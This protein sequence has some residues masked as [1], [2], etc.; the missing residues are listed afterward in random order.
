MMLLFCNKEKYE[1]TTSDWIED[2]Y[3]TS[4]NHLK[5]LL[6]ENEI[7]KAKII[8]ESSV[9]SN[10]YTMEEKLADCKILNRLIEELN[11]QRKDSIEISPHHSKERYGRDCFQVSSKK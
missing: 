1:K 7:S 11:P 8:I 2:K 3:Q 10:K 5:E 9:E 6:N 4:C